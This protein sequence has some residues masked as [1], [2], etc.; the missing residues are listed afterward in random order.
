MRDE[1][2]I[3]SKNL[4][5]LNFND[6]LIRDFEIHAVTMRCP[7]IQE[8]YLLG[9]ALL[10][11]V[12]MKYLSHLDL[13]RISLSCSQID[14]IGIETLVRGCRR[15]QHIELNQCFAMSAQILSTFIS[16]QYL[17]SL[18]IED[19]FLISDSQ[20]LRFIRQSQSPDLMYVSITHCVIENKAFMLTDQPLSPVF[21]IRLSS[22]HH[23]HSSLMDQVITF[24]ADMLDLKTINFN[25]TFIVHDDNT[26]LSVIR[27]ND[28]SDEG[29][30]H[31]VENAPELTSID[32]SDCTNITDAGISSI[33]KTCKS[34][35]AMNLGG[36]VKVSPLSVMM[37]LESCAS[38]EALK[39]PTAKNPHTL[40]F[41]LYHL[42]FIRRK[43]SFRRRVRAVTSTVRFLCPLTSWLCDSYASISGPAWFT[44]VFSIYGMIFGYALWVVILPTIRQL[45]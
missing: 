7:H 41:A 45:S 3:F 18:S 5:S 34:L 23:R 13:E 42:L 39:L 35:E 12:T 11:N 9:C 8:I 31:L 6:S 2:T 27:G 40:V 38:L 15:L 17:K 37:L 19:S 22:T 28:V 36:A 1:Y 33:A 32:L 44:I 16:C 29:L 20:L 21:Y 26:G 24:M 43:S 4:K 30:L 25:A 14:D 10:T